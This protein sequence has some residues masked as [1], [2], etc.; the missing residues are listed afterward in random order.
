M[1]CA[2]PSVRLTSVFV[3]THAVEDDEYSN[4]P[5]SSVSVSLAPLQSVA[6]VMK[7]SLS[8][9]ATWAEDVGVGEIA[10]IDDEGTGVADDA[11]GTCTGVV[12]KHPAM[13]TASSNTL[14]HIPRLSFLSE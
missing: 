14:N 8:T 1:S 2:S 13:K 9:H 6:A 3:K 4:T 5:A 7:Q 11:V 12:E 10:G